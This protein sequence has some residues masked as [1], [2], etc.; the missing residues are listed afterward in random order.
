MADGRKNNGGARP[1][2]GRRPKADEQKLIEKLS[3]LEPLALKALKSALADGES[4]AVKLFMEYSYGKPRQ[5]VDMDV[6]TDGEGLNFTPIS[7]VNT[8]K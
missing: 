1:G 8:D 5:Q 6:T 4:W 7:F 2:A 3:P